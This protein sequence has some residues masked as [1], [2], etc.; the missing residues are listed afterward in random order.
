MVI[1]RIITLL[2]LILESPL[3]VIYYISGLVPKNS[4]IWVI[5]SYH[6]NYNDN[7]KYLFEYIIDKHPEIL[8]IWLSSNKNLINKLRSKGHMAYLKYSLQGFYYSS[9][10]GVVIV[11][12]YRNNVN[13]YLIRK[14]FIVNLWH[15]IPLKKIEYDIDGQFNRNF[16]KRRQ[17]FDLLSIV[18]PRYKNSY[19]LLTA[20]S[21]IVKK[22]YHSAFRIPL[23]RI[24]VTGDPRMDRL[25]ATHNREV[26]TNMLLFAPTF[27][28]ASPIDFFGYRFDPKAWQKYLENTNQTLVIKLHQN[29]MGIE[30]QYRVKY[31]NYD[32]IIFLS[33]DKDLYS[34]LIHCNAL[35]TDFSSVM[36]DFAALNKPVLFLPFEYDQ[37]IAKERPLYFDYFK[38]IATGHHFSNWAELLRYLEKNDIWAIQPS[39]ALSLFHQYKDNRSCERVF[40]EIRRHLD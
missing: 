27:R 23:D 1:R 38:D 25:F 31:S 12:S 40:H 9:R 29:D 19:S 10:A 35:I 16:K 3:V 13:P 18:L 26:E 17:L 20:P 28:T 2:K 7:S 22:I 32:K 14:A 24:A 37:Y 39:S 11:S 8:I 4:R 36:F 5:G 21:E 33:R 30:N 34:I 6:D 15:G